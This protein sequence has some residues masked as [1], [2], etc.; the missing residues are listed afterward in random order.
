VLAVQ[1]RDPNE[2]GD[3]FEY[4][5]KERVSLRKNQSA[6]VPIVQSGVDVEK[7]SLWNRA[8]G[9]RPLRA[10]WLTNSTPLTLDGGSFT[11]LEKNTFAGEGLVAS[12]KPGE[13]RFLSYAVDLGV[14]VSTT[15]N[16]ERQQVTT[17]QIARGILRQRSEERE[18]VTYTIR[19][20]DTQAR[21]VVI[22]HPLRDEWKLL[23]GVKPDETSNDVYR[24][25]VAVKPKSTETLTVEESHP[26]DYTYRI[27]ALTPDQFT[28]MLR[29]KSINPQVEQALQRVL[30]KKQ[31]ISAVSNQARE[32]QA[33]IDTIFRDQ[34]RVREN[35]KAL[36]GSEKALLDRYT[37]QLD[38]QENQLAALRKEIDS[39]QQK[40]RQ[41]QDELNRMV[42]EIRID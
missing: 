38:D 39:L 3:L 15:Q 32:K 10:L 20:E 11:V 30:A 21:T 37:R 33:S 26:L 34:E 6:M 42:E 2:L 12:L 18:R 31:E 23:G 25:K 5:L 9:V 13:R 27:A 28:M 16:S 22:E 36:K 17:V 1:T 14:L 7:V 35:L 19:N 8:S 40:Q 29:Q 24:F 4:K 41:L